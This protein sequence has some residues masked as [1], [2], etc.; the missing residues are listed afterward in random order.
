M[1]IGTSIGGLSS[2]SSVSKAANTNPAEFIRQE[3]SLLSIPNTRKS[4]KI[5]Q[6]MV[7]ENVG[8]Q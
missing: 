5:R 8:G 7:K 2:Q 3:A 6:I 1:T 4:A